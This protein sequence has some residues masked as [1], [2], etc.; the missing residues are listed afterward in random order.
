M[1]PP[2]HSARQVFSSCSTCPSAFSSARSSP[3]TATAPGFSAGILSGF[4][5]AM[6]IIIIRAFSVTFD[7]L[8]ITFV[9]NTMIAAFLLPFIPNPPHLASSLW[10]LFVMGVIHYTVAPVL[11][12]RGMKEVQANTAAI[13]ELSR[14]RLRHHPRFHISA[15]AG[16]RGN[17]RRRFADPLFR[18]PDRP[19]MT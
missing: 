3:G 7:P 10:V 9:Q 14:A 6:L 19:F 1:P 15:G 17:S 2:S 4:A 18:L 16:E 5:Y 11:Y 13:L 8:F 12:L